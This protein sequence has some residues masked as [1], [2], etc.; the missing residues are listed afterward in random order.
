MIITNPILPP[1]EGCDPAPLP[2]PTPLILVDDKNEARLIPELRQAAQT[3][4]PIEILCRSAV[5]SLGGC[6]EVATALADLSVT[7]RDAYTNFR[8]Q[9]PSESDLV[10]RVQ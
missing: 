7:G 3:R 6:Q 2:P 5:A 9:K 4:N 1:E 8:Q 10:G